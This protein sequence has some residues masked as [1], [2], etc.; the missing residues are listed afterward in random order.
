MD[1]FQG[2]STGLKGFLQ[3][4]TAFLGTIHGPETAQICKIYC[5]VGWAVCIDSTQWFSWLLSCICANLD[6]F[7]LL[8]GSSNTWEPF[9]WGPAVLTARPPPDQSPRPAVFRGPLFWGGL[10]PY[11]YGGFHSWDLMGVSK[12]LVNFRENPIKMEDLGVPL[13]LRTPPYD[14][15]YMMQYDWGDWIT[16]SEHMSLSVDHQMHACVHA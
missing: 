1:E 8:T 7:I 15:R 4:F 6:L 11:S 10:D 16:Q 5:D 9:C 2:K 13:W 14:P 12:W 3:F